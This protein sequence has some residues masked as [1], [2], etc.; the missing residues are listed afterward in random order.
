MGTVVVIDER[1]LCEVLGWLEGGF[2]Y[3]EPDPFCQVKYLT[4]FE[5]MVQYCLNF[6]SALSWRRPGRRV[7]GI[8]SKSE[9]VGAMEGGDFVNVGIKKL[10]IRGDQRKKMGGS[11][12]DHQR[13][14]P[15]G[16]CEVLWSV[17][18]ELHEV[19]GSESSWWGLR[20]GVLETVQVFVDPCWEGVRG[21]GQRF[22]G[23][24]AASCGSRELHLER[25]EVSAGGRSVI[26]GGD[27][28]E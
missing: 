11:A 25:R 19:A 7:G 1:D 8:G 10:E 26:D 13:A 28:V 4:L 20:D 14:Q 18:P 16:C 27:A 15:L 9:A 21:G 23:V 3:G 24:E 2:G 5:L 17:I 12:G 6:I 22:E